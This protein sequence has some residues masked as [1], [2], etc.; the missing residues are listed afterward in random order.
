MNPLAIGGGGTAHVIGV[1]DAKVAIKTMPRGKELTLI[2][3]MPFT[4]AHGGVSKFLEVI[5]DRMFFRVEPIATGRKEY[6]GHSHARRVATGHQLCPRSRTNRR[7]IETGEL[8]TFLGH[9]VEI[10]RSVELGTVGAN[11]AIAHVINE[12]ENQI[13]LF[14]C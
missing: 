2:S 12:D 1:G 13:R 11:I 7:G 3:Q 8:A 5:G 14:L 4:H 6:A 10:G 9:A